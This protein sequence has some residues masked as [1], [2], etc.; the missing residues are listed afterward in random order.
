MDTPTLVN[1]ALT[2]ISVVIG[3]IAYL[4]RRT[5]AEQ[6]AKM[7]ATVT[8]LNEVR[9]RVHALET[10]LP[11]NYLT[12]QEFNHFREEMNNN[13]REV[14]TDLKLILRNMGVRDAA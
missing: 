9:A 8:S 7:A 12:K 6:D 4:S 2:C 5:I 1:I 11:Q 3:L 13:F 14:R 10:M